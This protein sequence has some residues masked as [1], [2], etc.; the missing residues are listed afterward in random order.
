MLT[1]MDAHPV[2]FPPS[3]LCALARE[4][5]GIDAVVTGPI[6]V[7]EN[8]A[9]ALTDRDGERS[10]CRVHAGD[11]GYDERLPGEFAL[12]DHLAGLEPDLA[13]RGLHPRGGACRVPFTHAGRPYLFMMFTWVPGEHR[14]KEAV[15]PA[16]MAAMGEASARFHLAAARWNA[17]PPR[18]VYDTNCYG[19]PGSFFHRDDFA[20]LIAGKDQAAFHEV[21][22]RLDAYAASDRAPVLAPIHFDLHLGNFL[23]EDGRARIIDFDECGYGYPLFDLGHILFA[24][25][26]RADHPAL[27]EALV[28]AY[29]GV[30]R[31]PVDRGDLRM[32]QGVQAL[33]ILRYFF[34]LYD[35][36]SGETNLFHLVPGIARATERIVGSAGT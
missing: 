24:L 3:L 15:T 29:E 31:Q 30:T 18:P 12:L 17:R 13:L 8:Y 35:R 19:G 32:F 27:T 25:H 1:S 11:P 16:D 2:T 22:R 36:T 34:R 33:A 28:T 7:S 4:H 10:F 20:N 5:Y 26:D 21:R 6:G 9:F 14:T 23:F